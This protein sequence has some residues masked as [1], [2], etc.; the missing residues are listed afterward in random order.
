[1]QNSRQYLVSL[2]RWDLSESLGDLLSS[3][4]LGDEDL[5]LRLLLREGLEEACR[6]LLREVER[7]LRE[8]LGEG[9]RELQDINR[10]N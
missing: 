4:D 2:L 10:R 6:F 5:D 8:R 1:M 9:L 7:D 3:F